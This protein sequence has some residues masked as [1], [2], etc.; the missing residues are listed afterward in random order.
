VLTGGHSP[1]PHPNGGFAAVLPGS[2]IVLASDDGRAQQR[3][4][5]KGVQPRWNARG[6]RLL[7]EEP[8]QPIPYLRVLVLRGSDEPTF[9]D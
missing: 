5:R 8:G 6:D 7:I 3:I 4:A 1:D 9:D 2:G